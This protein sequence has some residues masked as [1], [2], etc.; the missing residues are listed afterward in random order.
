M[1][2]EKF[3]GKMTKEDSGCTIVINSTMQSIYD[4]EALGLY[5]YLLSKPSGWIINPANL[6]KHFDCK[7]DKLYRIINKLIDIKLLSRITNRKKGQFCGYDYHLHLKPMVDIE[8]LP[9]LDLPFLDL[10][11][12]VIPDTY[13]TKKDL[14]NKDINKTKTTAL[15]VVPEFELLKLFKI[16]S[17]KKPNEKVIRFVNRAIIQLT[18]KE[19]TLDQY[20]SY[21]IDRCSDWLYMPWGERQRTND[22]LSIILKPAIINDALAGKYEDKK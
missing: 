13:K 12:P 9:F 2:I 16:R 15:A 11:L 4:F 17:P 5:A 1:S 10:P 20:L 8:D 19:T 7:K 14:Q 18:E 6:M 3:E 22:E 21:L